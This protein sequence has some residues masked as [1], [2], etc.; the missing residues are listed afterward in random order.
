MYSYGKPNSRMRTE[1]HATPMPLPIFV[2]GDHLSTLVRHHLADVCKLSPPN[3][4]QLLA[5]YGLFG[6]EIGLHKDDHTLDHFHST[7]WKEQTPE[8]AA[9]KSKGAMVPG[10]DVLIYTD[11][12]TGKDGGAM[13]FFYPPPGDS[14]A[15]KDR[16]VCYPGY[17]WRL[18]HGTLLLFKAV[19]DV[20][21]YHATGFFN[22]DPNPPPFEPDLY[23]FAFVF[24]W[25]APEQQAN[26]PVPTSPCA[27][28]SGA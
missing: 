17:T 11:A 1:T 19:D 7:L 5:Y 9:Q 3:H 2:M 14:F 26:F 27:S 24:R 13:H 20:N 18:G 15:P 21:F 6:S 10:S 16:Y 23:R 25:L 12:P 4:C 8:E 28:P 22:G